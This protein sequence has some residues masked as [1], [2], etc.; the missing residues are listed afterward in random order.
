MADNKVGE[1]SKWDFNILDG[2]LG[3]ILDIDM[4]EFGFEFSD[5]SEEDFGDDFTLPDG[6]KSEICQM[7]FTL[8][9]KQKELIEKAIKQVKNEIVETFGN[10]NSNGNA[11]Y[12]VVRQW[13]EQKK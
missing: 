1:Y 6:G 8:H 3:N 10:D 5:I 13:D 12:E 9:E 2:E 7:T 4:G 11:L